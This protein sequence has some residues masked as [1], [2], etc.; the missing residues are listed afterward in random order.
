M[1]KKIAALLT[2]RGNNTMKD[3]NV[4][5]VLGK[6]LLSYPCI[7]SKKSDYIDSYW[8]SSDCDKILKAASDYEFEVIDR[9][10]ELASSTA[11]HIDVIDHALK[12]MSD[13]QTIPDIL[14]V[15]LANTVTIKEEWINGCIDALLKDESLTACVPVYREMDHHPYRAK[16]IGE[17]GNLTP[18]F[19]FSGV[20]ISTNRQDLEPC[21]FLCHNF[22]VLNLN[23]IKRNI[24]Q[25][26]WRFMG[27]KVKHYEI[28]EA[29]D[30]HTLED[31]ERSQKWLIKHNIATV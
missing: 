6:P 21:Y 7:A 2:G 11:Q 25:Q 17:D 10:A 22:W 14:V 28:D 8:V 18:F 5:D 23:T 16:K 15:L 30:V 9:P 27:D 4:Y 19:D 29:F 12:V 26:P 31:I 20:N 24:G 1:K 3:K 13:N